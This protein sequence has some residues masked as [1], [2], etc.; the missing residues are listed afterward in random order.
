[1]NGEFKKMKL[2][3]VVM[4]GFQDRVKNVITEALAKEM[5]ATEELV[6][7]AGEEEYD[8]LKVGRAKNL[9]VVS[10]KNL[11]EG[12][13][14]EIKKF[15]EPQQPHYTKYGA[16]K[17]EYDSVNKVIKKDEIRRDIIIIDVNEKSEYDKIPSYIGDNKWNI[18]NVMIVQVRGSN[19]I[20]IAIGDTKPGKYAL[21]WISTDFRK[22]YDLFLAGKLEKSEEEFEKRRVKYFK[23]FLSHLKKVKD[24][25]KYVP[26]FAKF[27]KAMRFNFLY[28]Y[29]DKEQR[30]KLMVNEDIDKSLIFTDKEMNIWANFF[31][32]KLTHKDIVQV[33][34][35]DEEFKLT[36]ENAHFMKEFYIYFYKAFG[37]LTDDEVQIIRHHNTNP[38]IW[39]IVM[40]NINSVAIA[41]SSYRLKNDSWCYQPFKYMVGK[42][43]DNQLNYNR[44]GS[45]MTAEDRKKFLHF[46]SL[47]LNR[48]ATIKELR[49]VIDSYRLE[50]RLAED[51]KPLIYEALNDIKGLEKLTL[52]SIVNSNPTFNGQKL[53]D[54]VPDEYKNIR[55]TVLEVKLKK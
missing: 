1:L 22:C 33:F 10:E 4:D 42:I 30:V 34:D 28:K 41:P 46:V 55:K 53:F 20:Q 7:F 54:N 36:N 27:A 8:G 2:E 15:N 26:L 44:E 32:S 31:A 13:P 35:L 52:T 12:T 29:S 25:P 43:Y 21:N 39:D 50:G 19:D 48:Y 16:V 45:S 47:I 11:P 6:K 17:Y 24:K 18:Y 38:S 40:S 14:F 5:L 9:L 37:L 3:M 51:M 23:Y 49:S